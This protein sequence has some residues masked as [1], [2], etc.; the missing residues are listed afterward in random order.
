M[1]TPSISIRSAVVNVNT[2]QG[3]NAYG[4]TGGQGARKT[5]RNVE[6]RLTV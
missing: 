5:M 3:S 6:R 4:V 2:T 1:H